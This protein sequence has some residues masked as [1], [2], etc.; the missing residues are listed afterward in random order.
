MAEGDTFVNSLLGAA[1]I[2][3]TTPIV[4]FAPVAGGA[5]AGYLQGR[6]TDGGLKVGAIAG[7]ISVVP[8]LAVLVLAGNL[9]LFVVAAGGAGVPSVVGGLGVAVLVVAFFGL[10]L[11]VAVLSAMGGWLGSY[12]KSERII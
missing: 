12:A 6:N 4:P 1:V 10:L 7:L 9:F 3:L 11:Y 2:V 8:L 5:V